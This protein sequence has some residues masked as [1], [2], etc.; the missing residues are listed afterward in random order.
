MALI[1]TLNEVKAVLPKLVSNLADASLLPNFDTAEI[2]YLVPIVGMDLYTDFVT[3]YSDD[4]LTL[5]NEKGS[6]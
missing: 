6:Y 4:P 3:K 1:K 5:S 2:K